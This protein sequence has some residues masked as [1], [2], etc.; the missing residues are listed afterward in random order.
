MKI[1]DIERL[2]L[3]DIPEL[4]AKADLTAFDDIAVVCVLENANSHD[5][6]MFLPYQA[7]VRED[8]DPTT[9]NRLTGAFAVKEMLNLPAHTVDGI[10]IQDPGFGKST[11][12]TEAALSFWDGELVPPSWAAFQMAANDVSSTDKYMSV[13]MLTN[14]LMRFLSSENCNGDEHLI[15]RGEY[16][17]QVSLTAPRPTLFRHFFDFPY[18]AHLVRLQP[19]TTQLNGGCVLVLVAKTCA[20]EF[21][22]PFSYYALAHKPPV[23]VQD[24]V[25]RACLPH[26]VGFEADKAFQWALDMEHEREHNSNDSE[27]SSDN[28]KSLPQQPLTSTAKQLAQ[29]A[30]QQA[31]QRAAAIFDDAD[32]RNALMSKSAQPPVT[33]ATKPFGWSKPSQPP[34]QARNKKQNRIDFDNDIEDDDDN[35]AE[36]NR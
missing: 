12:S 19:D 3:V 10:R 34:P 8:E 24:E 21:P 4:L 28:N 17:P 20:L 2:V 33:K 9:I 11:N 15:C 31:R 23:R 13:T 35:G 5:A 27:D 1:A 29:Q 25:A 14:T 16:K 6:V 18:R 32:V 22:E 26:E 7:T 30:K 36:A